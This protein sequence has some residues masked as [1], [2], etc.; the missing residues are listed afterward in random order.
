M[1]INEVVWKEV[2]EGVKKVNKRLMLW[3][4]LRQDGEEWT[5]VRKTLFHSLEVPSSP[6]PQGISTDHFLCLEPSTHTSPCLILPTLMISA[7][8]ELPR[9]Q[10]PASQPPSW[11][12]L[13]LHLLFMCGWGLSL[14]PRHTI[15]FTALL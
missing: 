13:P 6:L 10:V 3:P 14:Q 4:G 9:L 2:R 12:L 8:T 11:Y 7:F 5:D 15:H 1:K